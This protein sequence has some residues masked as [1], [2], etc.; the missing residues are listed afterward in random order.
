MIIPATQREGQE[1]IMNQRAEKGVLFLGDY[2]GRFAALLLNSVAGRMGLPWKALVRALGPEQGGKP[3]PGAKAA[4]AAL[5]A[6]GIRNPEGWGGPSAEVTSED[7]EKAERIIGL[8][9]SEH[10]PLLEGRF[11]AWADRVE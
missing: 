3:G 6:R 4:L 7:L 5:E 1:D 2:R 10:R 9:R 11:P 8:S